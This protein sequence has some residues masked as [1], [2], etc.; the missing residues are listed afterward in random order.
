MGL[1]CV[2]LWRSLSVGG[3]FVLPEVMLPVVVVLASA[4]SFVFLWFVLWPGVG[5]G[6]VGS[7][8]SPLPDRVLWC[9]GILVMMVFLDFLDAGFNAEVVLDLHLLQMGSGVCFEV[10]AED[11]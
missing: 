4:K 9:G 2:L 1:L 3:V 5:V 6:V 7:P 11:E 8:H 10:S